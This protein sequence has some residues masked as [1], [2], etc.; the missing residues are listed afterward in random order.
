MSQRNVQRGF[1]IHKDWAPH[2]ANIHVVLV[3][4]THAGN[5][6][7]VARVM[8]N[9]GLSNLTLVS[10]TECGIETEAFSTA[11]GA[12]EIVRKARRV[13]TLRAALEGMVMAVG[14][15]ARLGKKRT[16]A[17][18]PD[19]LVPIFMDKA[20]FGK[21]AYVFGREARGLTNEEMK[22]CTD[23]LIIPSDESFASLNLAH[24]VAILAY[25][26]FKAAC[27]PLGFQ[28]SRFCPA[29]VDS[30]ERMYEHIQDVLLA[31]GFLQASDPLR[32][33]RDI[34]R[35]F[36][37]ASLDE[38]DVAIIRGMFRKMGN[39]IKRLSDRSVPKTQ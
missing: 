18:V 6:G 29:T 35:I 31:A 34:R 20:R 23:H 7:A 38:R 17:R 19:E 36:N 11:S 9:M 10:C 30:R 25:E 28:L 3:N 22:L 37:S 8:K 33:M 4:T 14:T 39:L 32:M 16:T 2:M 27:R 5:I 21:V 15:S 1:T 13:D 26:V 24:A 12:Y